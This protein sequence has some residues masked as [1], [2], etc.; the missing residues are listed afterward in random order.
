MLRSILIA[1][2][3]EIARRII[4]TAKRMG[5]RSVAVYSE[6]DSNALFVKE[7]DEG[8][9]LGGKTPLESYL[10]IEKIISAAKEKRCEAIHP[11]YGFLSERPEFVRRC[12]EE[13]IIFIGPPASV[14]SAMGD[15]V[16]ARRTARKLG[17]PTVPGSDIVQNEEEARRVCAEIGMPVLIKAAAGGGGIG[18]AL[19]DRAE[20]L[21]RMLQTTSDRARSAFGDGRVYIEKYLEEPHHIEIQILRDAQGN[22]LTFY[23]RECSIQRRHQKII[24][25][26]PSTFV[27]EELRKKLRE[28]ARKLAEG[29][30]YLNA[31]TIE[32]MVDKQ[33]NFYFLEANTRL[34]VEHPITEA[35]TGIDLVEM[36]IRIASREP[37]P[38]RDED[39]KVNGWAI[40]SRIYAEDP[41]RFLPSPGKI[42]DYK[43]PT[44]DGIRTDS[45]YTDGDTLSPFY[46]PLIAKLITHGETRDSA[47]NKMLFALDNY[48]ITGIKTNIPFLKN[49][50]SSHLF[51]TGGYDTHF[52]EKLKNLEKALKP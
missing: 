20:D 5:I 45:G 14:I 28:A 24:E 15:K 18:M 25:E 2:R 12:E 46:D 51:K 4:K 37:L 36:Q 21:P 41:E 11:G 10:A 17:V 3:G 8:V 29:I 6:I 7:A 31:G 26:S 50:I 42:K 22:V 1:N 19:V 35:I 52:V 34:Q 44:G 39:I 38:F 30:G 43:E 49:A 48:I 33:K 32:C 27:T 47:I 23:E 9:N 13:G 16:E 40:E